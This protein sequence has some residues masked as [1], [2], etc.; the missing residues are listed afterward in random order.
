M[1]DRSLILVADDDRAMRAMLRIV[2]VRQG[3]D[4][5]ECESGDDLIARIARVEEGEARPDL[6]VSDVC[7]PGASGLDVGHFA[8][9]RLPDVPLVLI[10]AFGDARTHRRARELGAAL[11]VDK[12][13]DLR[14]FC[15]TIARVLHN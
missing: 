10:T 7:M 15:Q 8:R 12:P 1:K 11:V 6:I 9:S 3:F 2:L 14:D 4:V 13:F 5:V